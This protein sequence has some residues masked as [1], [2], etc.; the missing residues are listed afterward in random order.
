LIIKQI[1]RRIYMVTDNIARTEFPNPIFER[2]NWKT[3]NGSW[4]FAFDYENKYENADIGK[5]EYPLAIQIPFCYESALS[6]IGTDKT[7]ENIWYSRLFILTEKELSGSI[8][9]KFGAVDYTAKVWINGC[10]AGRHDGGYTPFTFDI[11]RYVREGENRIT[12]KA[13]DSYSKEFPRG[14]QMWE[15]DPDLCWYTNSSGIWQS[16]WLEFTGDNYITRAHITPDVDKNQAHFEIVTHHHSN[17]AIK[18]VLSKNGEYLGEATVIPV[19]GKSI[20]NYTF[21]EC[22]ARAVFDL[23][24]S[25][26]FPVLIDVE[27]I[28]TEDGVEQDRIYTYFGMRK[29]HIEG[30]RLFINNQQ[31]YQ[32]LILDQGYWPDSLVTPPSDEAIQKDIQLTKAMGFNGARKHQK[33]EDPR[34]YYWADKLGLL[35]WGELPAVYDF[36]FDSR[37]RLMKEMCGFIERDYNHPCIIN[38]VPVNESWGVHQVADNEQQRDFVRAMYYLIKA[39]D[40][41]RTIS[42][43]DGWEQIETG[44]ICGVHDYNITP[45]NVE[46]RYADIY[47][48]LKSSVNFRPVYARGIQY[49]GIPIML[50]EMGGIKLTTDDGWGYNK[51]AENPEEMLGRI[52]SI[53]SFIRN[54]KGIQGYCYTQLTDIMKETNGLLTPE[55]EPKIPC[56][57]LYSIFGK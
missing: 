55:R 11:A 8:L 18:A 43:N 49:T 6:G 42:S 9:L 39:N 38:W 1:K 57:R 23:Y 16:V 31:L 40:Q 50:T 20:L 7:C 51:T 15:K 54:H 25:P 10:Y 52:Q 4:Q 32:R 12:V 13:Q 53:V 5:I 45:E 28:L 34:Y 29:I 30:D 21:E 33:M 27:L 44:D 37:C 24:W 2:K 41:T 48:V 19:D 46:E 14:K 47:S 26:E 56:E 22:S 35:V 3:L 17:V 36:T